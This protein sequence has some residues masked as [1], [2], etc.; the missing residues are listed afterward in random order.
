MFSTL[1][2]HFKFS[3]YYFKKSTIVI[4][5]AFNTQFFVKYLP[6]KVLKECPGHWLTFLNIHLQRYMHFINYI[7]YYLH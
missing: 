3:D 7:N 1:F 4:F 6:F 2:N 5:N